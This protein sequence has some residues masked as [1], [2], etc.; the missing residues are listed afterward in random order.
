MT[1]IFLL[2]ELPFKWQ[3]D[4]YL[5]SDQSL[6]NTL[7]IGDI[8]IMR[9]MFWMEEGMTAPQMVLLLHLLCQPG[10]IFRWQDCIQ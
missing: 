3:K 6:R 7:L 9:L 2:I 8:R 4:L 1:A 10:S 5:T